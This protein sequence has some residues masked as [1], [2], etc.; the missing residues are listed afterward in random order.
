MPPQIAIELGIANTRAAARQVLE[1]AELGFIEGALDEPALADRNV[2]ED[3][4][5]LVSATPVEQVDE[6]W[7]AAPWILREAG[8]G[9]R[10]SFEAVLRARGCDPGALQAAMV[11]PSNEAV[12][13]A[14]ECGAGWRPCRNWWWAARWRRHLPCSLPCPRGPSRPSTTRNATKPAPPAP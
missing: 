6:A 8:S 12:L 10:S 2:G 3:R 5:L 13:S 14:V 7:I 1:G 11:L 4:L 9:T